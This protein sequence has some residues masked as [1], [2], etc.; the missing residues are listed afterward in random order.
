M[1]R[2]ASKF[3]RKPKGWW[4]PE[5]V[6]EAAILH[7]VHYYKL[8]PGVRLSQSQAKRTQLADAKRE[9][10]AL[11]ALKRP[12]VELPPSLSHLKHLVGRGG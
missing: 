3:P 5:R 7:I 1:T 11:A 12:K 8:A 4:T 6:R 9:R 10:E 2:A